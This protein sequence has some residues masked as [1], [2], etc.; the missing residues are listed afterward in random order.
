MPYESTTLIQLQSEVRQ[1]YAA[2]NEG[3]R[4]SNAKIDAIEERLRQEEHA[5]ELKESGKMFALTY[6]VCVIWVIA[7]LVNILM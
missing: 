6:I 7:L 5:K 4:T 3:F 2:I 1:L